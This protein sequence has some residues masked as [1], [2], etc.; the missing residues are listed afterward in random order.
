MRVTTP[1]EQEPPA[2]AGVRRDSRCRSPRRPGDGP[3]ATESLAGSITLRRSTKKA[4]PKPPRNFR[5]IPLAHLPV[6]THTTASATL[7]AAAASSADKG[8]APNKPGH[9]FRRRHGGSGGQG[10]EPQPHQPRNPAPAPAPEQEDADM[11]DVVE[12]TGTG[13]RDAGGGNETR[14]NC[15]LW[16]QKLNWEYLALSPA[17]T[18]RERIGQKPSR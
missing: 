5:E 15:H 8:K 16:C 13:Y 11:T 7:A 12:V 3:G 2:S 10:Q 1:A 14:A 18:K 6:R 17:V 4:P 9:P